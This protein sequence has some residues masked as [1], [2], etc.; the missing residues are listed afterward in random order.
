VDYYGAVL[1]IAPAGVVERGRSAGVALGDDPAG[2]LAALDARVQARVA[3]SPDD[4][5]VATAAG[6]MR[7]IDY[8]P[9]RTFELVVH[10]ADLVAALG[11]VSGPVSGPGDEEVASAWRLAGQL[12]QRQGAAVDVLLALTGRRTLPEDFTLL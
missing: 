3:A 2:F 11:P 4:A 8:L 9:T 12:A 1:Q 10:T 6:G 7:L 5:Y